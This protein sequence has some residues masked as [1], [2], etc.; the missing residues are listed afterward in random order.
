MIPTTHALKRMDQR[1]IPLDFVE[2]L[3]CF[4]VQFATGKDVE[5]VR[6]P[7][8]ETER[9]RQRLKDLLQRWDHL[10]DVYA[11]VSTDDVVITTAHLRAR[12]HQRRAARLQ[13]YR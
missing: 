13:P 10:I 3:S 9:L 8:R 4:G 1:A 6:L 2:L 5:M 11:V 7:R 12:E